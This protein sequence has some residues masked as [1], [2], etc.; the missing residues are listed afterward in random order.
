[1]TESGKV[2]QFQAEVVLA[3]GKTAS[4]TVTRVGSFHLVSQ[5]K[6]LVYEGERVSELSRQPHRSYLSLIKKL[7][8]SKKDIVAFGLD[9]SRGTLLS[10]LIQTPDMLERIAQGGFI[11]YIILFL[12]FCGLLLS[13]RKYFWLRK[14]DKLLELQMDSKEPLTNN[15]FGDMI[16]VFLKFKEETQ[17]VLEIKMEEVI[18]Q[19]TSHFRQ[20]LGTL[21]LLA[22]IAPLL[23]LLGTV[24]GMIDTFQSLTLFGTGDP[25]LMAGGISQALVTTA[26]GLIVA[27]PLIF[28]HNF[29]SGKANSLV[30]FFEEQ[31]LGLLSQK[32][33]DKESAQ[34]KEERGKT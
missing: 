25:K 9:P 22:S 19:K 8:R 26:L 28:I 18:K 15:P 23:G 3:N 29:L 21:K 1:M 7:E 27:I 34:T 17:E 6:Y 16:Q 2:A 24:T 13:S 31:A 4:Q 33:K 10:L 5:G 32:Y 11:A 14:E 30:S 12:L 20:G